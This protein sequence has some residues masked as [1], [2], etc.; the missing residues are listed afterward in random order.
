ML[1]QFIAD[2][3]RKSEL[4][5]EALMWHLTDEDAEI[6]TYY[7]LRNNKVKDNVFMI[8]SRYRTILKLPNY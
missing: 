4:R 7:A 5:L 1:E 6:V 2:Q 8:I 3:A